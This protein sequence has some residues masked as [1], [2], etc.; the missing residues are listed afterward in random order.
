MDPNRGLSEDEVIKV[1][2]PPT[3]DER[4]R[5]QNFFFPP[6]NHLNPFPHHHPRLFL[7]L[8][9][10][11][12]KAVGT[13]GD[14]YLKNHV[15]LRCALITSVIKLVTISSPRMIPEIIILYTFPPPQLL[16][17]PNHRRRH[18]MMAEVLLSLPL[19]FFIATHHCT[20]KV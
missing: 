19:T 7:W 17:R 12:A 1:R 20:K 5:P 6:P 3:F 11:R 4:H 8:C 16:A 15:V 13:C 10:W 9:V 2:A 14:A 18:L